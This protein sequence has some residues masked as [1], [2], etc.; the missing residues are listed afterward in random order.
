VGVG[1]WV[2]V[3]CV[4]VDGVTCTC[5]VEV[6]DVEVVVCVVDDTVVLVCLL[7]NSTKLCAASASVSCT[8]SR[9]ILS[10]RYT[11]CWYLS[12]KCSWSTS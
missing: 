11:P 4:E 6:S 9:A 5:E 12:F 3:V 8:T 10:S 2:V 1:C 7:A